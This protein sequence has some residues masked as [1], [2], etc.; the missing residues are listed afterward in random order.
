[1]SVPRSGKGPAVPRHQSAP[2]RPAW[3]GALRAACRSPDP[4]I[5]LYTSGTSSR[6]PP[7]RWNFSAPARAGASK[8]QV[9]SGPIRSPGDSWPR[10]CGSRR[11]DALLRRQSGTSSEGAAPTAGSSDTRECGAV[12]RKLNGDAE[13]GAGHAFGRLVSPCLAAHEKLD[14]IGLGIAAQGQHVTHLDA[15]GD[16]W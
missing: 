14:S 2:R 6:N 16:L 1:M 12:S 10:F 8:L 3:L 7:R 9:A 4:R 13:L 15:V 5:Q 11:Y